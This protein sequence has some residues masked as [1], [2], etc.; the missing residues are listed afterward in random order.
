MDVGIGSR[1][2]TASDGRSTVKTKLK[3]L[4]LALAGI[5]ADDPNVDH[6]STTEQ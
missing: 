6:Q 4:T 5:A 2:L 1:G 3:Q